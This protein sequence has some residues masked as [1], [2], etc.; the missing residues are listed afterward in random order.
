[1]G[2]NDQGTSSDAVGTARQSTESDSV[3]TENPSSEMKSGSEVNPSHVDKGSA[4]KAT[5]ESVDTKKGSAPDTKWE[6]IRTRAKKTWS[7]L[8]DDDFKQAMGSREK[9]YGLI[10]KRVGGTE[11]AIK[12]KLEAPAE[13]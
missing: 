12:A 6:Q 10:Q 7:Q 11:E 13:H 9:L 2:S 1:M 3:G 5:H 4:M 8:T